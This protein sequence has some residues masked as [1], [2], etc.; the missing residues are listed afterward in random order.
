MKGPN[1]T[2][3]CLSKDTGNTQ[4]AVWKNVI[5]ETGNCG[6]KKVKDALILIGWL[7]YTYF[8][9]DQRERERE[10]ELHATI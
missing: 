4:I 9:K 3:V 7:S 1:R 6:K 8:Q 5:Q 2:I 10:R